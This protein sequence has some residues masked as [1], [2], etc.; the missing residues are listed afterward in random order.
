MSNQNPWF[1]KPDITRIDLDWNAP[2][3]EAHP[4]WIELKSELTIGEERAMLRSVSAVTAE[5]KKAVGE[6][7]VDPSAKF[8][9]TEYSFARM[10]AYLTGWSLT[11]EKAD[12]LVISR[13]VIGSFHKSLFDLIDDAVELH[14]ETGGAS[15]KTKPTKRKRKAT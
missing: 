13:E 2:N 15:K 7:N 11:D 6:P 8:D 9:W 10:T 14:I 3:G 1:V 12:K 5:V 4:L